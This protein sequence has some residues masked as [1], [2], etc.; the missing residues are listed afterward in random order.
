MIGKYGRT[1]VLREIPSCGA[2]RAAGDNERSASI[3][4]SRENGGVHM[5]L[6]IITIATFLAIIPIETAAQP[7]NDIVSQCRSTDVSAKAG[8]EALL[9]AL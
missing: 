8:A 9:S 1:E 7:V 2:Y 5:S 4:G 3:G 6:R